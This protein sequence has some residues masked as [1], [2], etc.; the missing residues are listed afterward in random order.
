[1]VRK[2]RVPVLSE[3]LE[4]QSLIKW[5]TLKERQHPELANLYAN[6]NGGARN[7]I[8]GARLKKEGV[9]AGIPDLTFAWPSPQGHHGLYIEM[10]R[11]VG[12]RVS[13]EQREWIARLQ[14]AGYCVVV[15]HG[16]LEA[17]EMLTAYAGWESPKW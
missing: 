14:Q 1:M 5:A 9:K 4:Q 11:T 6:A 15:A 17:V 16:W 8:T 12:G 13:P 2:R 7:K 3:S 10:K